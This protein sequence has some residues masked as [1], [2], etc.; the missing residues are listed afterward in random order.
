MALYWASTPA[1]SQVSIAVFVVTSDIEWLVWWESSGKF[2]AVVKNRPNRAQRLETGEVFVFLAA[3]GNQGQHF[4]IFHPHTKHST[5]STSIAAIAFLNAHWLHWLGDCWRF[6]LTTNVGAT[7]CDFMRLPQIS[8]GML[9]QHARWGQR[10]WTH[11][12]ISASA[13][14]QSLPMENGQA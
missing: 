8:T 6:P 5:G 12:Q 4:T 14:Q 10:A 13:R 2:Q 1:I 9:A 3:T 7:W 11:G